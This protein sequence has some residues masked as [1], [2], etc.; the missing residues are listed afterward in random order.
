MTSSSSASLLP[1]LESDFPSCFPVPP[2]YPGYDSDHSRAVFSVKL[3]ACAKSVGASKYFPRRRWDGDHLT[4][5]VWIVYF[6]S[7]P[8]CRSA[9]LFKLAR[10]EKNS[11]TKLL[12]LDAYDKLVESWNSCLPAEEDILP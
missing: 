6:L 4:V 1:L 10:F 5:V 2:R 9:I 12:V 3:A 7:L 8:L 11:P